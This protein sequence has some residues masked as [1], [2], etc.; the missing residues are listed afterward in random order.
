M[1]ILGEVL[2]KALLAAPCCVSHKVLQPAFIQHLPQQR[3][4]GVS[5]NTAPRQQE[6]PEIKGQMLSTVI[7]PN[8]PI[9]DCAQQCGCYCFV[10]FRRRFKNVCVFHI[11][12]YEVVTLFV[13]EVWRD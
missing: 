1:R 3:H 11:C 9:D 13:V 10:S 8:V 12:P 5:S 7:N 6:S 4:E 2:I